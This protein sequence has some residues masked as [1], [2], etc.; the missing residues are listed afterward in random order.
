MTSAFSEARAHE[1]YEDLS[2]QI[3]ALVDQTLEAESEEVED[4]VREKLG[5]QFRFWRS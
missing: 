5:E 3:S 1:I 4:L 2:P